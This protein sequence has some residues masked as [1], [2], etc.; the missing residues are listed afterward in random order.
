MQNK[1]IEKLKTKLDFDKGCHVSGYITG[2]KDETISIKEIENILQY[3]DQLENK[4]KELG[5]GK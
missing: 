2:D 3:I 5:K 1:E 4:I